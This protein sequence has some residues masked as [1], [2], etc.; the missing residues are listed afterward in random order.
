MSVNVHVFHVNGGGESLQSVV[1]EAVQRGHQTQVFRHA[2]GERLG[3]GVVLYRQ[4][5]VMTKQVERLQLFVVINGDVLSPSQGYSSDQLP[6]D[7]QRGDTAKQLRCN[8]S[9]RAEKSV[10]R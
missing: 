4:R 5:H 1:I 10:I 6:S 7:P 3:K 2:L 8:V 9:I